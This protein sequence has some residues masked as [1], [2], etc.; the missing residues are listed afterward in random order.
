M[1]DRLNDF[2]RATL[3]ASRA[4]PGGSHTLQ[5]EFD[6]LRDY[7]EL[8]SV[9]M[10][11]RLQFTLA[12]PADLAG[13][14]IP[15]LL[16]QPLVENSIKHGLEPKVEGGTVTVRALRLG[17]QLRLE[18]QDTGVGLPAGSTTA[19]SASGFGLAQVRERL[20]STYGLT[21]TMT[22]VAPPQGGARTLVD[23]P[24]KS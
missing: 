18:V 17:S 22:F 13:C 10:G 21:A 15:P 3:A 7:L 23:L 11:P 12:L 20:T 19:T 5:A 16:L 2:L 4:S 1:L 24:M 8:M 6:R 14:A 9:R